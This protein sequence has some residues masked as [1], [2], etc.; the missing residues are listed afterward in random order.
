MSRSA[1]K[2][3]YG[4]FYLALFGLIAYGVTRPAIVPPPSCTDGVQNQGEQGIDCGGPCSI[5]CDV[6]A[7]VPLSVTGGVD[8][9]GLSTGKAVLLAQVSNANEEYKADQ[10]FYRFLVYDHSDKLLETISGSSSISALEQK[11]VF[12]SRVNTNLQ[13]I[14]KVTMELYDVSWKKAYAALA[15]Q[16]KIISGPDTVL[17]SDSIS[18]SG[19][20]KNQSSVDASDVT[21]IAVLHD[22]YGGKVFASQ[23]V[24]SSLS[25]SAAAPFTVLF[26]NDPQIRSQIDPNQTEVF[27]SPRA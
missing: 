26:P 18:V 3:F 8:V 6:K 22:K 20:V 25:A 5:S 1:K 12:D 24:M 21:I 16:I 7:L 15:P 2:I 11:Y 23:W 14:G 10:F 9:F 4:V 19:S 17:G 13:E 27:I